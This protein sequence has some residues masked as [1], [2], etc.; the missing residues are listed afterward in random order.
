MS[1]VWYNWGM[2]NKIFL[3]VLL[4]LIVMG[5]LWLCQNYY[6]N[7]PYRK[8]KS[9]EMK[10]AN[11]QPFNSGQY[12]NDSSLKEVGVDNI[13]ILL[14][15]QVTVTGKYTYESN[16][17]GFSGYCMSDFNNGFLGKLPYGIS[18]ENIKIFCFRNEDFAYEKL[19]TSTKQITVII[20]NFEFNSYPS[21][22]MN[23]A[24]LINVKS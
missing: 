10:V 15:G 23:W 20:D 1:G 11:I 5:G 12:S 14:K 6:K 13:K 9:N 24:D 17:L 19:G 2:K 8:E 3:G 7:I 21:E 16:G 4:V 22:V 18:N